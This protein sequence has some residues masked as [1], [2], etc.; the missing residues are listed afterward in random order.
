MISDKGQRPN[1]AA[2]VDDDDGLGGELELGHEVLLS[3]PDV[4]LVGDKNGIS[5]VKVNFH[6]SD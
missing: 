3:R 6:A 1:L 5:H 2:G 4:D